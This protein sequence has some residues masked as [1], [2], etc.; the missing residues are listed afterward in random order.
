MTFEKIFL[1]ISKSKFG[2]SKTIC[3]VKLVYNDI[4][5]T[6]K[7]GGH[8]RF[9]KLINFCR[10]ALFPVVITTSSLDN[11]FHRY[12]A[13]RETQTVTVANVKLIFLTYMFD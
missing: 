13:H 12:T 5:G 8:H 9:S 4:L 2:I 11:I 3:K 7:S 1:I 6:H 10:M